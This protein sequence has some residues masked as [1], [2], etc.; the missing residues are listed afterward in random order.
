M[1]E[2]AHVPPLDG[3]GPGHEHT[4]VSDIQIGYLD[5]EPNRK[6]GNLVRID[7]PKYITNIPKYCGTIPKKGPM[8][9]YATKW[10]E[11][12]EISYQRLG[13]TGRGKSERSI[14]HITA[15]PMKSK[16]LKVVPYVPGYSGHFPGLESECV[17]S[18]SSGKAG[19]KAQKLRERNS[20]CNS[21]SFIRHPNVA[22]SFK[23]HIPGTQ[24]KM[25][26][27]DQLLPEERKYARLIAMET[28]IA[29]VGDGIKTMSWTKYILAEPGGL[30]L[31]YDPNRNRSSSSYSRYRNLKT[32]PS[33]EFNQNM[34]I[35]NSS[36][37]HPQLE[38][39]RWQQICAMPTPYNVRISTKKSK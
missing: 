26:L 39:Q 15:Y 12:C 5:K 38:A 27:H 37:R 16:G 19:F 11:G 33:S 6:I 1:P 28:P 21:D 22:L 2:L 24:L 9:T 8:N 29:P 36:T 3:G 35:F 14:N 30:K 20:W 10:R 17:Y 23:T 13:K 18:K 25:D 34:R 7:E 4:G 32:A 31:S